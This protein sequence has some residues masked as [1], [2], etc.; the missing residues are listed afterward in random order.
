[1]SSQ[2]AIIWTLIQI[3]DALSQVVRDMGPCIWKLPSYRPSSYQGGGLQGP[4]RST[5]V[6]IKANQGRRIWMIVRINLL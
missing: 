5:N 4:T 3:L 6:E 1:L 2:W